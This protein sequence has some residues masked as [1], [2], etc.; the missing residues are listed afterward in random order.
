MRKVCGKAVGLLL[1]EETEL[2]L[3]E[4]GEMVSED[5]LRLRDISALQCD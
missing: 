3:A 5:R 2:V 1:L 4:E